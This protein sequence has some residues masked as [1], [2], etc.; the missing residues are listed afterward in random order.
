MGGGSRAKGDGLA[1]VHSTRVQLALYSLLLIFTPFILLQNFLVEQI[2]RIS[3]STFPLGALHLPLVPA[4]AALLLILLALRFRRSISR[5]MLVAVAIVVLMDALAQQITDFYFGHRFYDLQQNWHYIA[6]GLFAYMVHRDLAPRRL[7]PAPILWMTFC[8]ALAFSLFDEMFQMRMSSR[9]FDLSDTA[10]DVWG[11]LMGMVLVTLGGR[12]SEELRRWWHHLWTG[13]RR[14]QFRNP[15]GALLFMVT[16]DLVFL[17]C[18][19]LLSD[20]EYVAAAVGVTLLAC[21]LFLAAWFLARSRWGRVVLTVSS[22]L[23]LAFVGYELLQHRGE[24]ITQHRYGITAYKGIPIPFFDVLIYPDGWFR[25]VDKK[26]FFNQRDQVFFLKQRTD[27]III[28][29]GERGLGGK[30][31]PETS[32]VQFLYNRYL[33]RATQV[34]TVKTPDACRLFNRL[35]RENK[36]ALLVIHNTC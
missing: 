2:A 32:M 16:F 24:F 5:R 15:L 10:K 13:P 34:I 21:A 18:G 20:V 3:G 9:V 36:N 6:Y 7:P 33:G 22:L 25:L 4:V 30:G 26:H 31:F 29:S 27:I 14:D 35:M 28:G 23:L 8:F 11:C 17:C 1:H 19:S 12:R